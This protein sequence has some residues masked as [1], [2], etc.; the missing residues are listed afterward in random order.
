M[1]RLT[2]K[3]LL[4]YF[5]GRVVFGI[6]QKDIKGLLKVEGF[7]NRYTFNHD[8]TKVFFNKKLVTNNTFI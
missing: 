6:I 1:N 2:K 3:Y 7:V 5:V 4:K 8:E